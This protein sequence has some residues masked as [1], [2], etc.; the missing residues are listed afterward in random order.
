MTRPDDSAPKTAA[1]TAAAPG[2]RLIDL[3]ER[4]TWWRERVDHL[5]SEGGQPRD[6]KEARRHME[7]AVDRVH[8]FRLAKALLSVTDPERRA[9]ILATSA[10]ADGSHVAAGAHERQLQSL[11]AARLA[12]ELAE[13]ERRRNATDPAVAFEVLLEELAGLPDG[14]RR[15]AADRLGATVHVVGTTPPAVPT[16]DDAGGATAAPDV[17]AGAVVARPPAAQPA[18]TQ[19]P[20]A[21]PAAD[22]APRRRVIGAPPVGGAA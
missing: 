13:Q 17:P 18:T 2:T 22:P 9:L 20:T 4:V 14:L 10:V 11:R 5:L 15:R 6:V 7:E 21:P 19:R 3:E 1:D 16:P 12:E 8:H